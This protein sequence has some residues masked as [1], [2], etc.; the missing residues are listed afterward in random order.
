MYEPDQLHHSAYFVARKK[1]TSRKMSGLTK[2]KFVTLWCAR[3][4]RIQY[5]EFPYSLQEGA[6]Y[7]KQAVFF[8]LCTQMTGPAN[9][10]ILVEGAMTLPVT[11]S[12]GVLFAS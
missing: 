7:V 6:S 10:S 2:L 1:R 11:L 4:K 8:H 9:N 3:L 12:G 5:T